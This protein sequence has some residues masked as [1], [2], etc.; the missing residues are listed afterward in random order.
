MWCTANTD[1][2]GCL[3]IELRWNCSLVTP[4]PS[5]T[6]EAIAYWNLKS[7]LC[8]FLQM[9]PYSLIWNNKCNAGLYLQTSMLPDGLS[10]SDVL[11][12]QPGRI[13]GNPS[14]LLP[15]HF[16]LL[17]P[18][19]YNGGEVNEKYDECQMGL[20]ERSKCKSIWGE[21]H[22]GNENWCP[23]IKDSDWLC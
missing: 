11:P 7:S 20:D 19:N 17:Y 12:S 2:V 22:I 15:E 8:P 13:Y 6:F 4:N 14:P 9:I 18:F 3:D 10:K 5:A 23:K 1:N 21:N 16:V